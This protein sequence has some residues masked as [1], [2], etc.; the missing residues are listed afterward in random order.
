MA[1]AVRRGRPLKFGRPARTVAV[2]LP[3]DVIATL[4]GIDPDLGRAI[5]AVANGTRH[6]ASGAASPER[7]PVN[8]AR[9]GRRQSL[10]VVDPRSIPTLPGCSL[11]QLSPDCAFIALQPGSRLAD[12][13]V[14]VI[15]QLAQ[16]QITAAERAGLL[17]LRRALRKWRTDKR[18]TVSERA[19]VLLKGTP[20]PGA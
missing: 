9:I 16:P 5:V 8:I 3:E 6:T 14:A 20:Q 2:T 10:I 11:C 13:E 7:L 4:R 1:N 12:L 19:I 17:A 15:D 18:V